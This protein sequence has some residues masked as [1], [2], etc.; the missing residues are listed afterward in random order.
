MTQPLP[1]P[2][3]APIPANEA[4]RLAALR[5]YQILDT[6]PEAAFDRITSL[7]TRLFKVPIALVSLVDESRAWFKS[8]YGFDLSEVPRDDTICSF[9]LL[10]DDLLVVPDTRLDQRFTCNPFVQSEPGLR[11]YA[12]APLLTKDGFNIGTLCLLDTQPHAALTSEQQATLADL[13]AIVIDELELRLA[14]RQVAQR[15]SARQESE[16]QLQQALQVGKMG[17]WNWKLSSGEIAWSEGHFILLGL[18][19]GE[20]AP[21]YEVWLNRVH[22]DDRQSAEAALQQAI[23][24]KTEY[25]HEYR[26]VWTDGSIH[27]LEA[28]G[29]YLYDADNHPSRMVGALIDITE[30]KQAEQRL[31]LYADV[32]SNTQIG[33]VVWQLENP[34][35]PGSFRLIIANAAARDATGIDF[36]SLIGSTMAERFP[37]LLQTSLVQDYINV[38]QTGVPV[39]FDDVSYDADGVHSGIYTLKAFALPGQCLG[40]TFENVTQRRQIENSLRE[41]EARLSLATS[42]AGMGTCDADLQT[43]RAIWNQQYF[44]LLGYDPVPSGEAA[45]EMWRSRIHPADLERVMQANAEAKTNQSLYRTEHRIIRADNHQVIW[46]AAFGRFFHRAGQPNRFVGVMFDISERKQTEA[47]L[48]ESEARYRVLVEA[49]PQLVWITNTQGQNEYVNRRFCDYTGLSTEQLQD[50]DWLSIIHPDDLEMTQKRW[51]IAV[52]S[53]LFYEIEYRFRRYDGT[54]RWFLGQGIPLKDQ[55]GR[56][57][58]WFGTCTDIEPQKQIEQARLRL[59]EQE[60]A[61]RASAEQANRI[62]D[63]FLAV[64]SHELRTPLNPILGWSRLLRTGSLDATKTA[65][66]L[67]TIERNAKLQTQ[68]I[69]DLLDVSRILQGKFS[70]TM[71]P[72]NLIATIEAALETVRLSAEAKSLQICTKFDSAAVQVLGDAARLQQVVWNLLSNA[73]K[74]TPD[75]GRVEICLE[76]VWGD[77]GDGQSSSLPSSPSSPSPPH[78]YAQITVADTGKGIPAGF[79]PHVFEYFR[80]ADSA[81]TRQF[82]GLGLGLA[83]VHHLVELHGGTVEVSSP[84]EGQGAAFTVRLPLIS[85]SVRGES[86]AESGNRTTLT[87]NRILIVDDETDTRELIAFVLEQAGANVTTAASAVEALHLFT[88][89]QFDVLISDIGMPEMDGYTLMQQVRVMA[90]AEKGSANGFVMPIAIALT[91][92]AGEMNQQQALAAGFQHH[93]A[94]PVE[95]EIL[96]RTIISLKA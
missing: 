47:A 87:G 37:F 64:L 77:G 68:L 67:E 10:S 66:A 14:A 61:A 33:I 70:L 21:S 83:I 62:K 4:E 80:Q 49:I 39:N 1:G 84:G 74:F 48:Q 3:S 28:R 76:Q 52:K 85:S 16:A 88:Q 54:Y 19:P 30:R 43:G 65:H 35:D 71:A 7:A 59:L 22:P 50:L 12:G 93:F 58:K 44:Q 60:Q 69:E 17:T 32:V 20:C 56:I 31:Q 13:A 81:T 34:D 23:A 72:V 36:E 90:E 9:A 25:R 18:Q 78:S 73:V 91:A 5:Q 55:Q 38:V 94:K 41:S 79:L 92:Y 53:A 96:L 29:N 51:L 89:S 82:G 24:E 75:G 11:F 57:V 27:W 8:C 46:V 42:G 2:N 45:T 95:L 63:E 15:E 6:P 86:R 26:T 40:L